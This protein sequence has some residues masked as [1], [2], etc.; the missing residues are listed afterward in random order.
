MVTQCSI[1]G[2]D[3]EISVEEMIELNQDPMEDNEVF[4]DDCGTAI[5]N[6]TMKLLLTNN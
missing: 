1:C 4:C 2:Q 5:Y 6:E 3:V